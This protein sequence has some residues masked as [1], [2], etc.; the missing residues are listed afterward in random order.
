MSTNITT[1][2]KKERSNV[3][4]ID[5]ILLARIFDNDGNIVEVVNVRTIND[6]NKLT[7]KYGSYKLSEVYSQ[8]HW[9]FIDITP[10]QSE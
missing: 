3:I 2:K 8:G 7:Y 10:N 9:N 4:K 1:M 6:V 5:D